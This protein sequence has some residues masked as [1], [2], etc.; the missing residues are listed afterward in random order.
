[1]T[2]KTK[3]KKTEMIDIKL[4]AGGKSMSPGSGKAP[5][6]WSYA[7]T[8]SYGSPYGSPCMYEVDGV[9]LFWGTNDQF[10]HHM[11][12]AGKLTKKRAKWI[13]E[14]LP[15]PSR[16]NYASYDIYG[17]RH[18]FL[19]TPDGQLFVKLDSDKFLKTAVDAGGGEVAHRYLNDTFDLED[20][21]LRKPEW[22]LTHRWLITFQKRTFPASWKKARREF[23][24][25]KKENGS[26]DDAK[27]SR[28]AKKVFERTERKM[29]VCMQTKT[30]IDELQ[31]Y[32]VDIEN[33]VATQKQVGRI[34][35]EMSTLS[36]LNKK[37]KTLFKKS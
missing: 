12:L 32:L 35:G 29:K 4:F 30:V 18:R 19:V 5:D 24:K 26:W 3:I 6:L 25:A 13:L 14:H 23:V 22:A 31:Q 21:E 1:M 11:P 2:A 9:H 37:V 33:D 16:R 8:F 28:M 20:D 10:M 34:Y 7:R 27:K 17:T 36:S 15:N